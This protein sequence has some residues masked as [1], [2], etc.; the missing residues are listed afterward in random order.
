MAKKKSTTPAHPKTPHR[1]REAYVRAPR[2][3]VPHPKKKGGK[4]GKSLDKPAFFR[5][6]TPV[7]VDAAAIDDAQKEFRRERAA[8]THPDVGCTDAFM[9]E[10]AATAVGLRAAWKAAGP[11]LRRAIL[12]PLDADEVVLDAHYTLDVI[13]DNYRF[14]VKRDPKLHA[15]GGLHLRLDPTVGSLLACYGQ[16]QKAIDE[17]GAAALRKNA[18]IGPHMIAEF[19]R[20]QA[21]LEA[22]SEEKKTA[23][24]ERDDLH[25]RLCAEWQ[26]AEEWNGEFRLFS[27]AAHFGR[28]KNEK[29]IAAL[30]IYPRAR[31]HKAKKKKT[32][33]APVAVSVTTAVPAATPGATVRG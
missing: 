16:F 19:A 32:A 10:G 21:D 12:D 3:V 18:K 17:I 6:L 8:Y 29:R 15:L 7:E 4:K 33:G 1:G 25:A 24:R 22:L 26:R 9:Q 31:D 27:N 30:R 5:G 20:C 28:K 11:D 13:R 23:R 14:W 2:P